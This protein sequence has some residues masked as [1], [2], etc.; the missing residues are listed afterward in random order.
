[1][2]TDSTKSQAQVQPQTI[3]VRGYV[4]VLVSTML[5]STTGILIKFLLVDYKIEPLALAFLRVLIVASAMG[6]GLL[7]FQRSFFKI[8]MRH[9]VYFVLM[10]ILGVGMH[11]LLWVNSVRLNGAGI[12]TVLVYI[13][14]TIVAL[15]SIRF[16]GETLDRNK[17]IAL[18]L[19]LLGII[20]V[21]Q[22]Y[23]LDALNVNGAGIL[24]GI[25]TGLTWAS[26]ALLGRYTAM[27]YPAWTSLFYAFLFGMLFLLPLQIFVQNTFSLGAQWNGWAILLFLSLGPTLGGFGLYTIGLS[28]VPASV[29]TLIGT[30]EPVF[31][32]VTAFFLFHE[33]LDVPQLIGAGLILFSVVLLRP[34]TSTETFDS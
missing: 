7:L 4:L 10:G 32:I 16:L 33:V 25:G 21:A 2:A 6:L 24:V 26:Y 3:T 1:M 11:Q 22:V 34:K 20:L 23:K 28:Q 30:L 29:V 8:Q 12:A 9:L 19:T 13:Q 31:T 17:I 5:M 15:I 18:V 14:P 27:R